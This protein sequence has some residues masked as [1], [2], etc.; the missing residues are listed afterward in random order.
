VTAPTVSADDLR[1]RDAVLQELDWD[2]R[3]DAAGI[4]RGGRDL[5]PT[6][7]EP[8]GRYPATPPR[9]SGRRRGTSLA[10]VIDG[11][12]VM[13]TAT[14]TGTDVRERDAV[15]RQLDWDPEVDASAIGVAARDGVITLT[16]F[17]DT[18][19]GKLAAERAAKRVHGVKAVAN[20][21]EVRLKHDRTDADIAADAA[22][23]L[24]LRD[25]VPD[26]I[27]ATVH[28]G[29][30]TLTGRVR[31]LYQ[32][33]AAAT[34]VKY[35]RGARGIFNHIEVQAEA[36][37]KDLRKRIVGAL[38]RNADVDARH[39]DVAIDKGTA[40]L[41]GTV[42][43]WLQREA[44]E[45]AVTHAP[46]VDAVDNRILVVPQSRTWHEDVEEIC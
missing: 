16:G 44:A 27:Q 15:L 18:Y 29:N 11:G 24:T 38:H 39:I 4:V 14:L 30:I 6:A 13:T 8:P 10:L 37:G 2:S 28:H 31:W 23:A 40:T 46:G 9:I 26:R 36:A 21:I 45:E 12:T 19:A 7:V 17:V 41:T 42:G 35:I 32:K 34:A 43:S 3:F 5:F 33:R 25:T 20:D 22:R 1:V